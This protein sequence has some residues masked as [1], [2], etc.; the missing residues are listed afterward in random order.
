MLQGAPA[1]ALAHSTLPC[2]SQGFDADL[3]SQCPVVLL[4]AQLGLA[5]A[6]SRSKV[7]FNVN[8]VDN[9]II[10]ARRA[11][12]VWLVATHDE[13]VWL[14]APGTGLHV[15]GTAT[16][17]QMALCSFGCCPGSHGLP[18]LLCALRQ[19]NLLLRQL[20]LPGLVFVFAAEAWPALLRLLPAHAGLSVLLCAGCV[21]GCLSLCEKTSVHGGLFCLAHHQIVLSRFMIPM[22]VLLVTF[23]ASTTPVAP[24]SCPFRLAK[25]VCSAPHTITPLARRPLPCWTPWTKTSTPS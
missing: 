17:L 19:A 6:F 10:Q 25:Q 9:M 2:G 1:A 20:G 15:F 16:T 8:R 11:V 18:V 4:Q 5:H 24:Q 22:P 23:A 13:V 7:K 12:C 3:R 21:F 14:W